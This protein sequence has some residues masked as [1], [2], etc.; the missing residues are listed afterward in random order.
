MRL[1][2]DIGGT[3]TDVVLHDP[4]R[5][6][7]SFAKSPTTPDDPVAGVMNAIATLAQ[8]RG[9]APDT[10]LSQVDHFVHGTTV[11]TNTLAEGS[12]PPLGLITTEG[13]RDVLELRDGTK[14]DRYA[15]RTPFPE[16]L[17]PRERRLTVPERM[18]W[19][20]TVARPLDPVAVLDATGRLQAAG[21][22][23][24]VVAFLHANVDPRHELQARALIR[25]AG[26]TGLVVLSH[27][28]CNRQGEYARFS[29]AAVDAYVTPRLAAYVRRLASTLN[30]GRSDLP[31]LVVQS[32]GGLGPA[33]AAAASGVGCVTSGPAGGAMACAWLARS[34]DV[35]D[36]VTF[37]IGGTTTDI[38]LIEG[39]RPVEREKTQT[40][41][42]TIA[43]PSID[44]QVHAIGGGS[45]AAVDAGGLLA[46]GPKSAGAQ[47]GPAAY[48][49]GGR[50]ATVTD[51]AV[52]LGYYAAGEAGTSRLSL[53]RTLALEAIERDVA[54]PLGL[55]VEQAALSV[56]RLAAAK[57]AEGVRAAVI[58]RGTD[59]RDVELIAFGG[60][61]GL[62][63]DSVARDLGMARAIVPRAASVFSALGF[64]AAQVRF[65][66]GCTL[67]ASVE[68]LDA[69]ELHAR[70]AE[71]RGRLAARLA[72]AGFAPQESRF[73][74]VID[75]R[76]IRQVGTVSIAA[77]GDERHR[78]DLD[79][80]V[81]AFQAR[82]EALYGH[83][84]AGQPCVFESI[85]VSAYGV[86]PSMVFPPG[87]GTLT[88]HA[89]RQETRQ[90]YDGGG[91]VAH[92][93]YAFESMRAGERIAGPA[94][95][96]STST[97][98]VVSRGSTAA[99]DG[100]G[101][102]I[103]DCGEGTP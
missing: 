37:D 64:L 77:A 33:E 90:V 43:V 62:Y 29:T 7:V 103:L 72:D 89:A 75:C 12:G 51:A 3:F 58:G 74:H 82:Y 86:A 22:Q 39:G 83:R 1:A 59:P 30:E 18:R 76:Y 81:E 49:R 101:S 100:A 96:E 17:I 80:L 79:R 36:A 10:L 14:Q 23:A 38:A 50:R 41:A 21:V 6:E 48:G 2:A 97:T 8:R 40:D 47:P 4:M 55:D 31:V 16:A 32:S 60:A 93:V 70:F 46:V 28:V 69:G 66:E 24:I 26:W 9:C 20:G 91:W 42:Y 88:A 102:V 57:V 85:R 63:A 56:F 13:F 71:I 15:L 87:G 34:M 35:A 94:L 98:I 25:Q 99:I 84:H 45:I 11:A 67:A 65:D 92:P 44:I 61:G 54:R 27:E 78:D 19:D 68:A 52:V 73:D 5:R 53:S 95:L